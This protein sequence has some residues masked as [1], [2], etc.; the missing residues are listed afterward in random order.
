MPQT[1]CLRTCD[2]AKGK[3]YVRTYTIIHTHCEVLIKIYNT[4]LFIYENIQHMS[5]FTK[6]STVNDDAVVGNMSLAM[7]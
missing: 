6:I 4:C 7:P 3:G 2:A 1:G 5:V